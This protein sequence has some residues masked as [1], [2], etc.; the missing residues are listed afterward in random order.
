A[1]PT[2]ASAP[3]SSTATQPSPSRSPKSLYHMS[4]WSPRLPTSSSPFLRSRSK[5]SSRLTTK[6]TTT[7][8]FAA[9]RR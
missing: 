5:L 4:S 7:P 2:S 6:N 8:T 1:A 3:F 9:A